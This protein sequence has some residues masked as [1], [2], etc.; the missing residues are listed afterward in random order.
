[1]PRIPLW[2]GIRDQIEQ[3]IRRG[4]YR[5]RE[6]LPTEASLSV[7]FGVNRH[8]VRRALADLSDRGMVQSRRGAGVFVTPAQTEYPIGER[9]RFHRNL[10]ASGRTPKKKFLLLETRTADQVEREALS[11]A[12]GDKVHVCEG[13]S[14][15]DETPIALFR[16]VFPAVAVPGILDTLRTVSSITKALALNGVADYTRASTRVTAK[17]ASPTLAAHLNIPQG[18]P[19]LRTTSLNVDPEGQPIEFG[20]TWFAGDRVTL[21]IEPDR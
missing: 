6:Q 17:A 13:L 9:V 20:Q 11:P 2:T 18:T 12:R 19:V 8:T 21:T 7:R 1:M 10:L 4:R 16:S 5:E 14:Y 3:D 15:A